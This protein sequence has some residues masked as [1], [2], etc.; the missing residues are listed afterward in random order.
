MNVL[1]KM[2]SKAQK[3]VIITEIHDEEMKEEYL[4]YRR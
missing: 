1:E 3:A 2:W 4:N